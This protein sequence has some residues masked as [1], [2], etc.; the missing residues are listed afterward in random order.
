MSNV[1]AGNIK[2]GSYIN[3]NGQPHFVVKTQFVSPGKG[4]AFTRTRMQNLYSGATIEFN[5]KSHDTIEE[6]DIESYEMQFLYIDGSDVVFMNP[7]DF[8]QITVNVKL[9]EGKEKFLI[10]D[11]RVYILMYE[12]KALG[13]KFPPKIKMKVQKAEDAVAGDRQ[14]AGRKPVIMETGLVVQAPLFIKTDDVLVVDTET[15]E[16]V[17]RAN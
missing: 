5:F 13:V 3:Y 14:T 17:S 10:P 12:E 16:Y 9:L 11:L 15:G 8:E 1:K 4:S 2:K 7:R 6:L